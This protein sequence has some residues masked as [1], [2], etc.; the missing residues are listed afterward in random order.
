MRG[1]FEL[2]ASLR[3]MTESFSA[4]FVHLNRVRRVFSKKGIKEYFDVDKILLYGR[5]FNLTDQRAG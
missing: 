5:Q 3:I 2:A 4:M 1:Y